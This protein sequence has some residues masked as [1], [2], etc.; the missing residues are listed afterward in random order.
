M[1]AF[2][3][4]PQ[5]DANKV[6][7]IRK[8]DIKD[9]LDPEMVL[10]AQ[11]TQKFAYPVLSLKNLLKSKPQYGAGESGIPRTSDETVRYVR[12]TDIDD[13]GQLI[14][15]LGV[16]A[17]NI[18]CQYILHNNDLLI[19]RS[20]NTVGKS[21][22]H[23]I[24]KMSSRCIF[25][26]YMIRFI[27][28]ESKMLPKFAFLYTQLQVYKDW[29]KAIQRTAGQPNI[30][31][32]EYRSMP[33]P[34]PDMPTQQ[35]MVGIYEQASSSSQQKEQQAA[36]LLASIDS[37]LLQELGI[38]L[39]EQDNRLEKRMFR[40]S[41]R[42][43]SGG[44]LDPSFHKIDIQKLCTQ[45]ETKQHAKLGQLISF[46]SEIWNQTD[47]FE[48][49]FP[50]IEIGEINLSTG[51]IAD[52]KKLEIAD[53]PSR[54][55]MIVRENDILVSLTRPTRGAIALN[56]H[57]DINIASTGFAV[58]RDLKTQQL[59]RLYLLAMLRLCTSLIQMG[60]RSTGGNYPAITQDELGQLVIPLLPLD[61]QQQ[62]VAHIQSIRAQAA[63][64]K[65]EAAQT[66]ADAKAQVERMILGEGA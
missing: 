9:R 39:P 34:T 1:S 5:V 54:A 63:Q 31:A 37:Y 44:R 48:N 53:A 19:A 24:S 38:T 8:K 47:F 13:K 26:G 30:N 11:L 50:Y 61:S 18:D 45:I 4:S 58:L 3:L 55:R 7:L 29:V 41:S 42:E 15:G 40:V 60:Q 49:E 21:Y 36:A 17:E 35:K 59:D 25:A 33:I 56:T 32:E 6:F 57:R 28:D 65:A 52:I 20:G 62:I 10:Y 14:Q 12:I 22:L 51:D 23:D 2:T 27:I 66:L 64:L 16:T 46:S 43:V